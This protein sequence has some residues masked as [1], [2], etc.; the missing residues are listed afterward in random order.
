MY[1][2][3]GGGQLTDTVQKVQATKQPAE[4]EEDE[5]EEAKSRVKTPPRS[6]SNTITRDEEVVQVQYVDDDGPST[7]AVKKICAM[8]ED[9]Q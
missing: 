5:E 7:E 3:G 6:S 2:N 8:E 1:S 4:D 9:Q